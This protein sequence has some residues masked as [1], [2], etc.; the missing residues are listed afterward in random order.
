MEKGEEVQKIPL[1]FGHIELAV[2][3]ENMKDIR[4]FDLPFSTFC[5][6]V[7]GYLSTVLKYKSR[8]LALA[9]EF[10]DPAR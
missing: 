6:V 3:M 7:T 4:G 10:K 5:Q 2:A 8:N 9:S 1:L